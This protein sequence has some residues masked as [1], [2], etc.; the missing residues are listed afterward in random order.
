LSRPRRRPEV[1]LPPGCDPASIL[2]AFPVAPEHAGQRLDRFIQHRI[3]RLSRTRAQEVVR[4][5]AYR[6]DGTRRRASERV[7][8]GETVLLV[9]PAFEEPTVPLYFDVLHEDPAI[10]AIDKPPGL[11][12]HP[13]ATYHKNTLTFLLRQRY[14]EDAPQIAH[15][16]DRDTSGLILCGRTREAEVALKLDFENRNVRKRYLAIVRGEMPDDEGRIELRMD[17]A[18]EGLHI[19]M[20]VTAEGEGYPSQSRYRVLARRSGA[21]LVV[22]A[23]ES[24]RQHQL[25]VHMSAIGFPIVGDKLYG[26]EGVEPF[27]EYIDTGMTSAL[28]ARLGH[29]RHALHAFE[30]EFTHPDTGAATQLRAPLPDDLVRLWGEPLSDTA[31]EAAAAC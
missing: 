22:L 19:L 5:C 1:A 26:P 21:T 24:G 3:P 17:R 25:R 8:A 4:A 15:R 11:P 6:A 16:L 10:L 13:S 27:L 23:P 31:F 7:K 9:R 18:K 14:G 20:E 28:Q 29:E 12:V 2:L 30:L